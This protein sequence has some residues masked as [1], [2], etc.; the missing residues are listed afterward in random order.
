MKSTG[1]IRRCDDLG[2]VVIPKEIRR[3]LK[4]REGSPLEIFTYQGSVCFKPYNPIGLKDWEKVKYVLDV[5]LNCG[6]TLKNLDDE[7]VASN[8][9]AETLDREIAICVGG[10]LVGVL[11][12]NSTESEPLMDNAIPNAVKIIQRMITED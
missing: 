5:L 2:R 8:T 12:V 10:E 6:Y 1:I 4:I 3:T 11:W 9:N 7:I